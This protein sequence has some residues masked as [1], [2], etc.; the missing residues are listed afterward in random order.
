MRT[1]RSLKYLVTP[2]RIKKYNENRPQFEAVNPPLPQMNVGQ[3]TS[4][5]K[6]TDGQTGSQVDKQSNP[7]DVSGFEPAVR[8]SRQRI[9]K[10]KQEYLVLF[11]DGSQYW[12]DA[13]TQSLLDN[14]RMR[15]ERFRVKRRKKKKN[16]VEVIN[17]RL[18]PAVKFA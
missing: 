14:F 2:A 7:G 1:G 9:R 6:L 5:G 17:N 4:D 12:C 10:G 18:D 13:V 3:P 15:Q 16:S 8:I 11:R